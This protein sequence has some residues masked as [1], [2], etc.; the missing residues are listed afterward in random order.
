MFTNENFDFFL[1]LW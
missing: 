1:V